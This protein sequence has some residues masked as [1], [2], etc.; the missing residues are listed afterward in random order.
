MKTALPLVL[1]IDGESE[2]LVQASSADVVS[3]D[4]QAHRS[5]SSYQVTKDRHPETATLCFRQHLDPREIEV[6]A[7]VAHVNHA[8]ILSGVVLDDQEAT[9]VE[10]FGVVPALDVLIP[11]VHRF[12]VRPHGRNVQAIAELV[13]CGPEV[14][15]KP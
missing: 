2:P 10:P 3:E 1:V 12:D 9:G 13:V 4:V 15:K 7:H 11:P 14:R 6:V 5:T 8:H